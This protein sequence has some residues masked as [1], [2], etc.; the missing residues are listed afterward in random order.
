MKK[1]LSILSVIIGFLL[2]GATSASATSGACSYHAGVNCSL[3]NAFKS[4]ICN[5]GASDSSTSYYELQECKLATGCSTGSVTAYLAN[6]GL[7][8]SSFGQAAQ[9]NCEATNNTNYNVSPLTSNSIAKCSYPVQPYC[10][11]SD[12]NQ[13]KQRALGENNAMQARRGLIGSDF[14]SADI[15]NINNAYAS[16]YS[17]CEAE[18]SLY[19]IHTNN[20]DSCTKQE[21]QE[22]TRKYNESIQNQIQIYELE[23]Q[24][25]IDA[26]F[27][28]YFALAMDTLPQYKDIV[29]S[30][31]IKELSLEPANGN[32]TLS[33]LI[34]ETYYSHLPIVTTSIIPDVASTTKKLNIK[35]LPVGS[36]T[37][38][39]PAI[40]RKP[41]VIPYSQWKTLQA[42]TTTHLAS[43]TPTKQEALKEPI[44]KHWYQ[45]LDLFSWFK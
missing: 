9:N 33:Q 37:P 20:Y 8:G 36:Y 16:K 19:K 35:D 21:D 27:R 15:D 3:S 44:K 29:D 24:A 25:R 28:K 32:K 43:S 31:V 13:Q 38:V 22:A 10:S 40:P 39:T 12:I 6:R 14:G 45:W 7:L 11:L 23:R 2:L 34:I 17:A 26:A 4:V 18:W 30:A 5:D 41:A 1:Y 42:T